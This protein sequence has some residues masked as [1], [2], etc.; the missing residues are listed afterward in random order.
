MKLTR[1]KIT[2][3]GLMGLGSVSALALAAGSGPSPQKG[4]KILI[5][6]GTGFLGPHLV[7][8]AAS[9]GHT[10]T[11]FNRGKTGAHLFPDLE[12]IKGGR[13]GKLDQLKG[14][15][16]DVVIDTSSF[17]PNQVGYSA[18]LLGPNI[19][20]YVYIS[21]TAVYNDYTQPDVSED[22]AVLNFNSPEAANYQAFERY[23]AAK[24]AC[25]EA[26]NKALP[27]KNTII[28]SDTITGPG[29]HKHFRLT[30]WTRR[31]TQ[32]GVILGPGNKEDHIQ[33]IDARDLA[34]WIVHCAENSVQGTYNATLPA[35]SYSM[36]GLISDCQKAAQQSSPVVW[37][38]SAFLRAQGVQDIPFW[39][40]NR[41]EMPGLGHISS[42]A[43]Q[44]NGLT[45]RPT[46][47]TSRDTLAWFEKLP[48]DRQAFTAGLSRE[49]EQQLLAAWE[50]A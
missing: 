19:G 45:L 44:K 32:G 3:L 12:K 2:Q 26:V 43:A 50:N 36:Q 13:A 11:L 5:L 25:E 20:H 29:D 30:Y 16:W 48:K 6:G 47:E 14:R 21:S 9:R 22:S 23:G 27:N 41:D 37:V 34:E 10:L 35:G 46:L 49:Q 18:S 1:R 39:A 17:M 4:L 8:H 42:T 7:R 24:F 28:R 31:T 33:Y 38:N 15:K 40:P